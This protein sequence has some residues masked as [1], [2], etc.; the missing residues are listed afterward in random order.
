MQQEKLFGDER[1][2]R[3]GTADEKGVGLGL[4]LCAD[5]VKTMEGEISVR[6]EEGKGSSFKVQLPRTK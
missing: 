2:V 3:K 4:K 5:F 6:S 1:E